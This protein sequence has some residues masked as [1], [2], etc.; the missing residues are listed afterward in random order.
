MSGALAPA[1]S[2]HYREKGPFREEIPLPDQAC[3]KVSA[4]VHPVF[5]GQAV[6]LPDREAPHASQSYQVALIGGCSACLFGSV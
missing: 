6:S 3:S 1:Q 4:P 5:Q 2:A